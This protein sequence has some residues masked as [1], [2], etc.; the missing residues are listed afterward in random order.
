VAGDVAWLD[1]IATLSAKLPP[2]EEAVVSEVTAQMMPKGGGGYIKFVGHSD[3]SKRIA[4]IEENLRDKQHTASGKGMGQDTDRESL[5]WA[6]DETMTIAA[7]VE[8]PPPKTAAPVGKEAEAKGTG[9]KTSA[10]TKKAEA[11]PA[12]KGGAK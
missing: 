7:P 10:P 3:T 5:Q 2:P 12:P 6:F 11:A 8:K 9:T 1:E 4:Q